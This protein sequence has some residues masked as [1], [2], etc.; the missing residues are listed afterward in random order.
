MRNVYAQVLALLLL[1][2]TSIGFSQ[3]A[4]KFLL[5]KVNIKGVPPEAEFNSIQQD[6]EGFLWMGG[7]SGLYRY[8]GLRVNRFLRDP[9]DSNSLTHNYANSITKDSLGNVWIGTFGG[10]MNIYDRESGRIKRI[11]PGV[12]S[13]A[14]NV[15]RKAGVAL[16]GNIIAATARGV[17]KISLSGKVLDS[18]LI[19]SSEFMNAAAITDLLEYEPGKMIITSNAGIILVDWNSKTMQVAKFL[20]PGKNYRCIERDNEGNFWIGSDAKLFILKDDFTL[21]GEKTFV[22]HR[23]LNSSE[24]NCLHKDASGKI[25]IGTSEGLLLYDRNTIIEIESSKKDSLKNITEIFVDKQATAWVVAAGNGLYQVYKPSIRFHTIPGMELYSKNQL[26]QSIREEQPGTWTIG[27]RHGLYRYIFSSKKFEELDVTNNPKNK[28]WVGAQ[29]VDRNNGYWVGTFGQGVYYRPAGANNFIQFTSEQT[30]ENSLPFNTIV[31]LAEDKGG[32]IWMGSYNSGNQ[33]GSNALCYYDIRKKQIR[34]LGMHAD[35]NTFQALSTSQ[36]ERDKLGH[37]WVGTWDMGVYHYYGNG[38]LNDENK[39]LNYS[40]IST[41]PQKISHNVVSCI[42]PGDHGQI[43]FGTISGGMNVL[44]SKTNTAQWFTIKDGLPSNLIYRIEQD[45]QGK[46]WMSTDN[47]IARFDP[48]S[49]SFINYNTTSGLPANDF[50]FLTSLKCA[51]GT[52][53][54]GTNNGQV[55]YFNPNTYKN[56]VNK[57]PVKIADIRLFN[58]SL[59][60]GPGALLSQAAYL[61]NTLK[62]PY[63]QSVISFE[64]SNMDFLNPEIY[65][66]A[67]KLEGFDKDWIH[68]TDRNSITYTNLDPGK[69][70]L[71][72]KNANHLGIWNETPTILTLVIKP[73]YWLTWWF[74]ALVIILAGALISFVFRYRLQQKLKIFSVRNRLHRDL[75]DDVGAT[76]SSVKAYSEILRASPDNPVIA[77]LIK[78]NSTEMLERLEVISWATNPQHDNFQS[79][80]NQMVKFAAPLCHSKNIAFN[81]T[82]AGIKEGFIIAGE[83]RQ[84]LL[85]IF[86]EAVNNMAKYAEATECETSLSIESHQ[87]I[88]QVKDNGNGFDGTIKGSG[89]GLKN[90]QKRSEDMNGSFTKKSSPGNGTLITVKLPF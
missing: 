54:F 15:V 6:D 8:D 16:D 9:S 2:I 41:P 57:L 81:F 74:V 59:E 19:P 34:R 31:S 47:G 48:G 39:F 40:E 3:S 28:P 45:D 62:L 50:A 7:L 23:K 56:L 73:P 87:F 22:N 38:I 25:W 61:T 71:L 13:S 86:K 51:D 83:V 84:N 79:L 65:T 20:P 90:M 75:H 24:I 26:I 12:Q 68:I 77:E 76:L 21:S 10:F 70:R 72:I 69:Y 4:N 63:D 43:W 88:L 32:N 82:H 80:K 64:L 55:V 60:T 66:Y 89:N 78:E 67:Y 49:K 5:K 58:K 52:I 36:I 27:T 18:V 17:F 35:E 53:A 30:N 85:L 44:D 29:F 33:P 1:T 11:E 42:R 14:R 46:V 37:M